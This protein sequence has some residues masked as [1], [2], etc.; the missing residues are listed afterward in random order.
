MISFYRKNKIEGKRGFTLI[1]LIVSIGLFTVVTLVAVGSLLSIVDA[2]KKTQSLK[3]IVNNLN[4]VIESVSKSMRVGSSY[5][6]EDV[7]GQ[8]VPPGLDT[9]KDCSGGGNLIAFEASGGD[10]DDPND[11]IVYRLN[12]SQIERS[13]DGGV[14]FVGVTAPEVKI[15]EG[16]GFRLFVLGSAA[17]DNS[18]PKAILIIRGEVSLSKRAISKF[19]IQTSISQRKIDS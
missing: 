7:L 16:S 9:P 6:C 5:H 11:Q 2:N 3:S 18:Q 4:F 1:E 17:G 13:T 14:N 12:G 19:N 15:D 8:A 10:P